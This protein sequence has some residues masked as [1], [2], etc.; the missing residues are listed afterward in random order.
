MHKQIEVARE[1]HYVIQ[2]LKKRILGH[3]NIAFSLLE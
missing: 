3:F 1:V 2:K